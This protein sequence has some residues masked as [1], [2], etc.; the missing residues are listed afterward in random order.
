MIWALLFGWFV[1]GEM[2][3]AAVLAGAAIVAGAGP[4][5]LWRER[6]LGLV[7]RKEVE[8]ASQR[9]AGG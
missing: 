3:T 6:R 1:F 4:F 9:P 2:P 7:R 8:T 5:V